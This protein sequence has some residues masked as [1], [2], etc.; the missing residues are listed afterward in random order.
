MVEIVLTGGP[1]AGKSSALSRIVPMLQDHGVRCLVVPELATLV[2]DAG[3]HDFGHIARSDYPA[4]LVIEE[5]LLLMQLDLERRFRAL[6]AALAPAPVVVLYDRGTMDV[7]SYIK[8]A[9][10]SVMLTRHGLGYRQVRD[11][12]DA[13]V[14]MVSAACAGDEHYT[15]ANNGTRREDAAEA[16]AADARTLAA[17]VG[18]PRLHIVGARSTFEDKLRQVETAVRHTVGIPVPV[19]HER[20]FLLGDVDLAAPEL[21][22]AVHVAIE[23]HYLPCPAGEE[24]RVRRRAPLIDGHDAELHATYILT[25]KR[26][27]PDG[28]REQREQLITRAQFLEHVARADRDLTPIRKIRICFAWGPHYFELDRFQ[29]G[30]D[31]PLHVLEVELLSADAPVTLPPFLDI[32]REVTAERAYRNQALARPDSVLSA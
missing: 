10:F 29:A 3:I 7:A 9:D 31:E 25:H 16:R 22:G 11:R 19:E 18:T 4:Y 14:H 1:G 15:Q 13:V 20:K 30:A 32:R 2:H 12:Y 5:Q 6:A 28:G 26:P 17:W 24:M 21:S 23:Q 27:A 8:P